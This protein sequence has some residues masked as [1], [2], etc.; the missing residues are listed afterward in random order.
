MTSHD[1][2]NPLVSAFQAQGFDV[3]DLTDDELA[4]RHL[5]HM[6]GG[7]AAP[8]DGERLYCFE[9]PERPGAL[10]RFLHHMQPNWNI[11]L[12]DYHNQGADYGHI[13]VGIQVPANEIAALQYFLD[14]LGYPHRDQSEHPAYRRLLRA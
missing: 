13:L 12:F 11:S 5:R 7:H 9:F 10:S 4:K 14:T 2:R 3:L 1:E 8:V 6:L